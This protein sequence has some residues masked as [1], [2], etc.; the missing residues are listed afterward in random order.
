[1]SER[2]GPAP[3]RS[4]PFGETGRVR[5]KFQEWAAEIKARPVFTFGDGRKN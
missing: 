5:V 4:Y 2:V 3:F 1:M